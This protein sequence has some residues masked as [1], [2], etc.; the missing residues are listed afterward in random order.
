MASSDLIDFYEPEGALL[1]FRLVDEGNDLSFESCS[2]TF[3]G[4]PTWLEDYEPY[5]TSELDIVHRSEPAEFG[6]RFSSTVYI[7]ALQEGIAPEQ[8]FQ[9][10]I[11]KPRWYKS[12]WEIEEW[13]A[14]VDCWV[15]KIK[16]IP[17]EEHLRRWEEFLE[18]RRQYKIEMT[19]YRR[20][21]KH[22]RET[23]VSAMFL[24]TDVYWHRNPID[25]IPDGLIIRLCSKHV[26]LEEGEP[27]RLGMVFLL[28][29]R[30]NEG[31]R[32]VA[33]DNLVKSVLKHFPHLTEDQ[34]KNLP[35]RYGCL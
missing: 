8:P 31:R 25:Y 23:D 18:A 27:G 13:D 26:R 19:E 22:L 10:Y 3:I 24:Q 4:D 35:W 11:S 28:E 1:W 7:W 9:V 2:D 6:Y 29:G 21:L 17:I 33:F 20:K 16:R 12:G 14:E 34:I 32:E 15:E 30:D 5:W